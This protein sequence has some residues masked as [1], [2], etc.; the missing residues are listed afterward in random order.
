MNKKKN[1][2]PWLIF[3]VFIALFI[4]N[5]TIDTPVTKTQS[6]WIILNLY[7]V[8]LSIF[9]LIK[10]KL[11]DKNKIIIS[12]VFSA[13]M[14]VAYQGVSL[15]SVQA[16]IYT[17]LCSLASFSIFKKYENKAIEIFKIKTSKGIAVSI[18]SGLVVGIVWG[19][20]NLLL[21]G[22]PLSL[23]INYSYFLHALSPAIYEE[24]ALRMFIYAFCIHLLRGEVDSKGKQFACYFMM[25][26]P[27]VMIH[28]PDTFINYGLISGIINVLLLSLLFGLPFAILQRKRDLT[29]AMIAH[30]VVDII[31]FCFLGM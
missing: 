18:V 20:L 14:F 16:F 13:L 15:S 8:I 19:I 26:V 9:I 30:G 28:T 12:S 2:K 7:V 4:L 1:L 17:L 11:P 22:T 25:I 6:M 10:Y 27:H 5:F 31:R 29:S 24:I 3:V 21:S 23:N